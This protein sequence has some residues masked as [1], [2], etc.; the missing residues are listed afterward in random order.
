MSHHG[1]LVHHVADLRLMFI[2]QPN[3]IVIRLRDGWKAPWRRVA[4]CFA[5]QLRM[6]KAQAIVCSRVFAQAQ[7]AI[8]DS[9]QHQRTSR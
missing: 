7:T 2:A 5:Q 3:T 4:L 8:L 9:N 1:D 6:C